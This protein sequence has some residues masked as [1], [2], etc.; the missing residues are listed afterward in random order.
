MSNKNKSTKNILTD[1]GK[2]LN[3]NNRFLYDHTL[4]EVIKQK[5]PYYVSVPTINSREYLIFGCGDMEDKYFYLSEAAYNSFFEDAKNPQELMGLSKKQLKKYIQKLK[6]HIDR[7]E[8]L[9]NSYI[10]L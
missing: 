10:K 6:E 3:K 4:S 8:E 9:I 5:Y 7:H 2:W 1:F